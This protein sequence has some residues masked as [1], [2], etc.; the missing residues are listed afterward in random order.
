[1][2]F[3]FIFSLTVVFLVISCKTN[4]VSKNSSSDMPE[5]LAQPVVFPEVKAL[6]GKWTLDYISPVDGKDSKQLYKIQ[7]PYLNFVDHEKVAGNNGCNNISGGYSIKDKNTIQFDTDKFAATRMFCQ[8]VNEQ[9]FK[10]ALKSVNK[11]DVIDDG[12]KLV[13]ITGDIVTLSFVKAN[14]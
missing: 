1:M 10:D 5:I 4:Q 2:K 7:M 6:M 12:K 9:A 11:F 13:L 14:E 3:K 8:G